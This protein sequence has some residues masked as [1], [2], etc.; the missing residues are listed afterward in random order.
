MEI[1]RPKT[2]GEIDGF[3]TLLLTA[4]DEP[5][6]S[7]QIEK[8]LEL[9]DSHR[10][11]VVQSMVINLQNAGAPRD[12]TLAIGCLTDDKVA[13]KAYEVI[14]KCQRDEKF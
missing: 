5:K 10:R 8:M 4:C 14:F 11:A 12:L 1:P 9:P 13:E 7:E 3:I 6:M 2:V